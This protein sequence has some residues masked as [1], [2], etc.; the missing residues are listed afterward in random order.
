MQGGLQVLSERVGACNGNF[1]G[2]AADWAETCVVVEQ[3]QPP[4][5]LITN[6][7]FVGGKGSKAV[8]DILPSHTG[9]VQFS[10]SSF[11]GPQEVVARSAGTG[12]LSLSQ[13]NF[14]NWD[15][16]GAGLPCVEAIGGELG[17]SGCFFREKKQQITLGEGV[18]TA[19]IT[20]NRFSGEARI[21]NRSKGDVQIGLNAENATD[22]CR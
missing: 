13:C 2:I 20:G 19:V 1:L 22:T 15:T 12:Y 8:V 4:G 3:T 10:N 5:L 7:E 21:E 18:A 11:W 9:V 17:I 16:G 14:T 6:G